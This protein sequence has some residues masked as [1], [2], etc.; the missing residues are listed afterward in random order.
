MA[1]GVASSAAREVPAMSRLIL[2]SLCV[3]LLNTG[4]FVVPAHAAKHGNARQIG[5]ELDKGRQRYGF[6]IRFEDE[7]GKKRTV[8]FDLPTAKVKA[9]VDA[10]TTYPAQRAAEEQAKAVKRYAGTLDGVT[11]KAKADDGVVKLSASGK[12]GQLRPAL[13]EAR[14]VA[15]QARDD[16]MDDEGFFE[17]RRNTVS[18]DHA[19][20]TAESADDLHPLADALAEGT[21]SDREFVQ[22]A[23]AFV[24]AIPYEKRTRDTY[25]RPMSVLARNMGDCDGKS[26][27]F[28][29]IVRARRP[30][31]PVAVVYTRN[32]MLVGV[33]LDKSQGDKTFTRS[34]VRYVVAEPVGPAATPLGDALAGH[35]AAARVGAKVIA[36]R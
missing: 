17:L 15:E 34:G 30:D 32:H 21:S 19:R 9:A 23:L 25:R 7:G 13:R 11:L 10:P 36:V 12:A 26:V 33:G 31:L 1:G 16:F 20:I 4:L 18:F 5:H 27:L 22:R 6:E 14:E 35:L 28:A 3:C 24:Q 2:G 8:A 29:A